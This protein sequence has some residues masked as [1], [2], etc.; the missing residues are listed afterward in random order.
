MIDVDDGH[1]DDDDDDDDDD[2]GWRFQHDH[3]VSPSPP[4]PP[5][6]T[7]CGLIGIKTERFPARSFRT[8][9]LQGRAPVP[10]SINR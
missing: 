2:A 4:N 6:H 8:P 10:Q 7:K 9:W 1:D 5:Y 3:R